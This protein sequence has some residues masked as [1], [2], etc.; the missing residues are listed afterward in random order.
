MTLFQDIGPVSAKLQI[1][2]GVSKHFR[3]LF[4]FQVLWSELQLDL[5]GLT[6]FVVS[7]DI[8]WQEPVRVFRHWTAK[9]S[10]HLA[11]YYISFI[12]IITLSWPL[13]AQVGRQYDIIKQYNFYTPQQCFKFIRSLYF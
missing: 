3:F 10:Y 8:K 2:N 7:E 6:Q 9:L 1:Y 4:V 12:R 11:S 5:R 13:L